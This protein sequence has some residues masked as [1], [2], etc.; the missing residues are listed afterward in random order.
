MKLEDI[1]VC[2]IRTEGTQCDYETK[3][4]IEQAMISLYS[5]DRPGDEWPDFRKQV[6]VLRDKKLFEGKRTL[7]EFDAFVIPGGFSYGDWIRSGA[8]LGNITMAKIGRDVVEFVDSGKAVL[9]ICNGFQ[10]L[11]EGGLLPAFDGIS[12]K[13][14][15]SLIVNDPIGYH[16]EWMFLKRFSD[17]CPYTTHID[18]ERVLRIPVAN[19]EGR[20]IF[21][22]AIEDEYFSRLFENDQVVLRYVNQEGSLANEEKPNNYN[23]TRFDVA[24][25]CNPEGNVFGL[26][27][28]PERASFWWQDQTWKD[29]GYRGEG[30]GL[31]IFKGMIRYCM[32][33]S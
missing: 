24:G 20:F 15:A 32:E 11:V 26:M 7:E 27:P 6:E 22:P 29:T 4:A 2:I 10:M 21:D 1:Q 28:H 13:P 25:I 17:T 30:D 33:R 16:C 23:G 5:Y 31:E 8:V 3:R 18:K 14:E 12:E 9:G 19:G